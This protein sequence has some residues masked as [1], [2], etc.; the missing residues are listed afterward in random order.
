MQALICNSK[1]VHG[2]FD[3]IKRERYTKINFIEIKSNVKVVIIKVNQLG[4]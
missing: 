3:N 2:C 1:E 4:G